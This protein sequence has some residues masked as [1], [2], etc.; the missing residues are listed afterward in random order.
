MTIENTDGVQWSLRKSLF[1]KC[2]I[3]AISVSAVLWVGWPQPQVVSHDR[4]ASV[5]LLEQL[6]ARQLSPTSA[7]GSSTVDGGQRSVGERK[8][9]DLQFDDQSVL[10]DINLGSRRELETLPG[11][12]QKLADRIVSYRAIHGIFKHVDDVMKVAGIGK[13]RLQRL[14]PFVKVKVRNE[15]RVS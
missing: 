12:G 6:S 4:V 8:P 1:L 10:I 2:G 15:K 5:A 14:K 9:Q 11:I 3:L 7:T 13:K